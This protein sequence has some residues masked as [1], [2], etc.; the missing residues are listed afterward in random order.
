MQLQKAV[1]KAAKFVSTDN[2]DVPGLSCLRFVSEET[3]TGAPPR[4]IATN[5]RAGIIVT[6]DTNVP[7]AVAFV[8]DAVPA[9]KQPVMKY[10]IDGPVL[11]VWA[12]ASRVFDVP[13]WN[14]S[15]FPPVPEFPRHL[16]PGVD[17]DRALHVMHAVGDKKSKPLFQHVHFTGDRVEATDA[18]R[19]AVADAQTGVEGLLPGEMF[20]AWP[21]RYDADQVSVGRVSGLLWIM[22]GD[23]MRWGRF[24]DAEFPELDPYVPEWHPN[25]PTFV[26]QTKDLLE[27]VKQAV[28]VSVKKIIEVTGGLDRLQVRAY[29][30]EDKKADPVR[31]YEGEV[32]GAMSLRGGHKMTYPVLLLDGPY[33]MSVLKA[34]K[35]PN[36]RVCYSDA[37]SP[38]RIES[39]PL[40]E[41]IW[42]KVE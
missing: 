9:F 3:S 32:L 34:I 33:L 10:E 28:S 18:T 22:V 31:G 24:M 39:G 25:G 15:A 8:K 42:P 23:E 37:V 12:T 1:Q 27:V 5:G 40:V 41:V 16:D 11:K 35:T 6:T 19:I 14:A 4:V 20:Q 21:A 13:L 29:T 38:V 30:Q 2:T 36:V 7:D 17:W 26:G